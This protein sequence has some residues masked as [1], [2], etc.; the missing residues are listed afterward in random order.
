MADAM[1]EPVLPQRRAA[2]QLEIGW[3]RGATDG[4]SALS[5]LRDPDD[6]VRRRHGWRRVDGTAA[7]VADRFHGMR[8]VH[9]TL[10]TMLTPF[11]LCLTV[12]A[13]MEFGKRRP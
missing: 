1:V 7:A 4:S 3:R 11:A 12:L 8:G 9:V 5:G 13:L 10:A 6:D 2:Y